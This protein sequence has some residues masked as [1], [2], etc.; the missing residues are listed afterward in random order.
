[1][2]YITGLTDTQV[3]AAPVPVSGT[4]FQVTQPVSGTF[5]QT[6]QPVSL[7]TNTP[8]IAAGSAI[9][10]K[11]GIDQTT[12]G[13]TNLVS[14]GT[15]GTVAINAALPAGTNSI[16]TVQ[17]AAITKA[18]QGATGVTTQDLKDAGRTRVTITTVIGGVVGV[19]TEALLSLVVTRN[20]VA[21]AAA[22]SFA[23]TSGKRLRIQSITASAR[24]T[25]ATVF[26][27][28]VALRTNPTGAAVVT[29][30]LEAILSMTQ[31][32]AAL[33]EAG[34]TQSLAV[35]DGMEYAGTEQIG[36]SQVCSGTGGVVYLTAIGFEY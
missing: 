23:V 27:A 4:F 7:A 9:I 22:T 36:F 2:S 13:T 33:A 6:T 20:G 14:I 32:A 34:D 26:S 35:P 1:M 21:A 29:S 16:G 11:V 3:R 30:P 25:A 17:Q 5:W 24:S 12:P 10:G 18:T 31:Q 8:V 28:R 19:T 15:N